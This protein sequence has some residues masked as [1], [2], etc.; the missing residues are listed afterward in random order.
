MSILIA[1]SIKL[2]FTLNKEILN[3]EERPYWQDN[4]YIE[5]ININLYLHMY[6]R[7]CY[8]YKYISGRY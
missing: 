6:I 7:K 8:L 1:I 4:L 5:D 3:Y 2:S